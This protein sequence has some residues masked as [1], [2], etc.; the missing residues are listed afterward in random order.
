[1]NKCNYTGHRRTEEEI[2]KESEYHQAKFIETLRK[3]SKL[4]QDEY[5]E[6]SEV[7][8]QY[9]KEKN[10]DKYKNIQYQMGSIYSSMAEIGGILS[11]IKTDE[12]YKTFSKYIA[13]NRGEL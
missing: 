4:L 8:E 10:Y 6:L 13:D 5:I 1:M 12:G 11:I 2:Q 3:A 9:Q 7:A